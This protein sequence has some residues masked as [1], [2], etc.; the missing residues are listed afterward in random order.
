MSE[1]LAT[2]SQSI[3]IVDL[4]KR[5]L[6]WVITKTADS[7]TALKAT[8]LKYCFSKVAGCH[9]RRRRKIFPGN[10]ENVSEGLLSHGFRTVFRY[11]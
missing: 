2:I 11:S 10:F 6:G 3:F 7:I 5:N 9:N 8:I 4:Q 1:E